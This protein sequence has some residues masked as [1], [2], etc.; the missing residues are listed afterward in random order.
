MIYNDMHALVTNCMILPVVLVL[1][2]LRM[3]AQ[4][5]LCEVHRGNDAYAES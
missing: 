2:S 5:Q 1:R 3:H 4:N